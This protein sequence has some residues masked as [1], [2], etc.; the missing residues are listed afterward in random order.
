MAHFHELRFFT[1]LRPCEALALRVNDYE[2]EAGVLAITKTR[3]R[4]R[5]RFKT[6]NGRDRRIELCARAIDVLERQLAWRATLEARGLIEHDNLFCHASGAPFWCSSEP[7]SCW[8]KT[9]V[10]LPVR[11]RR[12]YVARHTSVSWRLMVGGPPLWVAEQHGHS[13]ITMFTVYAAWVRAAKPE[14]VAALRAALDAPR[15]PA[16]FGTGLGH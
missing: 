1:G 9:L 10:R 16:S 3:V 7:G 4:G 2:R 12:P 5:E 8:M 14:D 15:R 6:K 11:Y 13:V